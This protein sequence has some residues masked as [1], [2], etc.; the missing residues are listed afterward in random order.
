MVYRNIFIALIILCSTLSLQA[1]EDHYDKKIPKIIQGE[2][3]KRSTFEIV[4]DVEEG[5]QINE[6]YPHNVQKVQADSEILITSTN[7]TGLIEGQKITY[8]ISFIPEVG[9]KFTIMGEIR[10]SLTYEDHR[11][12]EIFHFNVEVNVN[13]PEG[14]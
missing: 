14:L 7:A 1:Q 3:G 10:F 9:G 6:E 12:L 11:H 4:I 8:P 5:I 2:V 13:Q